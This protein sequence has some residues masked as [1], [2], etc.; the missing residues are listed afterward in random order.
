MTRLPDND[1]SSRN[2]PIGE[3]VQLKRRHFSV[4]KECRVE[5]TSLTDEFAEM[6]KVM[7]EAAA[8]TCRFM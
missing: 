1:E 8:R 7:C 3:E 2:N 6:H 5:E 4:E